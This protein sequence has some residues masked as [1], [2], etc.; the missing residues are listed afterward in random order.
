MAW[1]GEPK[2]GKP[3][4][5]LAIGNVHIRKAKISKEKCSYILEVNEKIKIVNEKYPSWKLILR[6]LENGN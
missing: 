3:F 5:C 6:K 2:R 4:P 1:G